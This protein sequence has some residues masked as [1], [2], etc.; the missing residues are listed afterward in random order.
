MPVLN[1][2]S[3]SGINLDLAS[4]LNPETESKQKQTFL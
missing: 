3:G 4:Q 1:Q 2:S